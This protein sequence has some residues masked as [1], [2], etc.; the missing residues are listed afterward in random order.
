MALKKHRT[1]MSTTTITVGKQ[2]EF[3]F[4]I[5]DKCVRL[6]KFCSVFSEAND[7]PIAFSKEE[8]TITIKGQTVSIPCRMMTHNAI[9]NIGDVN[10][11]TRPIECGSHG[12]I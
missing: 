6:E 10:V 7:I 1:E 9:V 2:V 12:G 8:K 4:E 3:P 5:Y 11:R